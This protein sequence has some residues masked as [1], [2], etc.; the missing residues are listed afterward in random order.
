MDRSRAP[1]LR[2]LKGR[3][4]QTQL[5]GSTRGICTFRIRG[6]I[7]EFLVKHIIWA[8]MPLVDLQEMGMG[9]ATILCSR[10]QAC[11]SCYLDGIAILFIVIH[12]TSI[13][14]TDTMIRAIW[15]APVVHLRTTRLPFLVTRLSSGSGK[16]RSQVFNLSSPPNAH[17]QKYTRAYTPRKRK[18][19]INIH[20][21]PNSCTHCDSHAHN[22]SQTQKHTCHAR[23]RGI[24]RQRPPILRLRAVTSS[25]RSH[26]ASAM[27]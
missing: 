13:S 24:T 19:Y 14:G 1:T 12:W 25:S 18:T 4:V 7:Q 9:L 27:V 10:T 6:T 23:C 26:A 3:P 11:R 8:T 2:Q 22:R 5:F 15:W 21:T 20:T 16:V 17:E